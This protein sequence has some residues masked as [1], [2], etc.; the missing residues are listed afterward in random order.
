M[1]EAEWKIKSKIM[2]EITGIRHVNRL[3]Y[4]DMEKL[5]PNRDVTMELLIN[6]Y[7]NHPVKAKAIHLRIIENDEAISALSRKLCE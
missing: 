7:A 1:D 2:E 4:G 6:A 3:L 5:L